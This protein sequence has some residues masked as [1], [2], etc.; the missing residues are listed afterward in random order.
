MYQ[1]QNKSTYTKKKKSMQNTW[2]DEV[3]VHMQDKYKEQMNQGCPD[4]TNLQTAGAI[5]EEQPSCQGP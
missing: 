1:K 5:G 3:R 4:L 2:L